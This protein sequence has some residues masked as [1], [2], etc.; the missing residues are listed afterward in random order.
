[1]DK[2]AA[3]RAPAIAHL[4]APTS[5]RCLR[6]KKMAELDS[7]GK[8]TPRTAQLLIRGKIQERNRGQHSC[9]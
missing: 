9:E 5:M 6:R 8:G 2:S 1:M 4:P 7:R 3:L